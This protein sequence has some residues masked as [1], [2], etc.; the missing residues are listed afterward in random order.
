[1]FIA[2]GEFFIVKV[3]E[4][5]GSVGVRR[6]LKSLSDVIMVLLLSQSVPGI[7]MQV[8]SVSMF[9][10]V[11]LYLILQSVKSNSK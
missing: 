10:T 8:D 7:T 2:T 5:A 1:M 3:N 9:S 4:N 6:T 11:K